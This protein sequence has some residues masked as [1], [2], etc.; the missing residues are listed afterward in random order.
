[1]TMSLSEEDAIRA[2]IA[3]LR[4]RL[5]REHHEPA[6]PLQTVVTKIFPDGAV[7]TR[8]VDI[9][10]EWKRVGHGIREAVRQGGEV[11][12]RPL[13][14]GEGVQ[15]HKEYPSTKR[16]K[17]LEAL[18]DRVARLNPDA[19]EV[20]PGMLAQLVTEARGLMELPAGGAG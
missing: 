11:T 19:G 4:A 8:T 5:P 14:P 13:F 10:S 6:E 3:E 9:A 20:G 16:I 17:A 1:M 15:E 7:H 18:V 12:M 2:R